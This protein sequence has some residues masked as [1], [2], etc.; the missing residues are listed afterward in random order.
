MEF[1]GLGFPLHLY[2]HERPPSK[3]TVPFPSS[4]P[5]CLGTAPCGFVCISFLWLLSIGDISVLSLT[6]FLSSSVPLFLFFFS[7]ASSS[8]VVLLREHNTTLFVTAQSFPWQPTH[9]PGMSLCLPRRTAGEKASIK[10]ECQQVPSCS[11]AQ[12]GASAGVKGGTHESKAGFP[13]LS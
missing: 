8:H 4:R 10:A 6:L 5:L 1:F 11:L 7:L 12:R 9:G 13:A 3:E 2:E